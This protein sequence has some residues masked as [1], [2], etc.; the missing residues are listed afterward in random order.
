M[1]VEG[2]AGQLWSLYNGAHADKDKRIADILLDCT[3]RQLLAIRDEFLRIP[4]KGL[5]RQAHAIL[6]TNSNEVKG[7]SVK[8]S[9]GKNEVSEQKRSLAFKARDDFRALK[10]LFLGR[11]SEEMKLIKRLYLELAGADATDVEEG[12]EAHV[13]RVFSSADRDRLSDLL[14]G[15]SAHKEAEI[16]HDMLFPK[17]LYHPI[18]DTLSDPRDSVDRDHTQGIGP[19]LRHFRKRRMWAG[20]ESIYHRVLNCYEVLAERIDAL[21]TERFIATNRALSDIY[22]YE[23]DASMFSSRRIFDPRMTA[24]IIKERIPVAGDFFEMVAPIHLREPRDCLAVQQA[25]R[26]LYGINLEDS[27]RTRLVQ[28]GAPLSE[29]AQTILIE[30]YVN[31]GGR[32]PLSIDILGRYRGVEAEPDVWQWEYKSLPE[33]DEESITLAQIMDQDLEVGEF[34]RP[35]LEFLSGRE[36]SELNRI[37]RAFFELTEPCIALR[38]ALQNCLSEEAFYLTELIFAGV[39]LQATVSAL[40]SDVESCQDLVDLPPSLIKLIREGFERVHFSGLDQYILDIHQGSDQE[41]LLIERLAVVLTPE[42]YKSRGELLTVSRA[43]VDQVDDIRALCRGPL[44]FVMAFE[45][46]FDRLFPRLRVQLKYAAARMA[47]STGVFA[48]IILRLEGVDPDVPT[49]ILEYFDGVDIHLL[50]ET[51]RQY[52]HE[53][54]VI[55]ESYDLLNP[56]AQLKSCIKEMKVDPDLIN[57]T[58]LHLD[59]YS[60]KEVAEEINTIINQQDGVLTGH[61]LGVA[62]L[63]VLAVPTP[64]R[65]NLRI[66]EDI[67]WMDEMAYQVLLAYYRDYGADLVDMCRQRGFDEFQLEE[68][69][70]RLFGMEATSLA[71]ELFALLKS[72]KSGAQNTEA[73][74]R[75]ILSYVESR[76]IRYRARLVRAYNSFWAYHTGFESLLDDVANFIVDLGVRKKLHA[77]LLAVGAEGK[78]RRPGVLIPIQ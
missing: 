26:V 6:N 11:S 51:L 28:I 10:Y 17:G 69:T 60:A 56:D 66:P 31:G 64:Q 19:Y 22:G 25:Y 15:W 3:E 38:T 58:L 5:A 73:A 46:G 47:L 44:P 27:I 78:S 53:Q 29:Q 45:R 49:L 62:V 9:I 33:D 68:L 2:V 23:L 35:V 72:N 20:R 50:L 61:E 32:W 7:S 30:R 54:K 12:L 52:K 14:N 16:I 42:V 55:E 77:L 37:E 76:G 1:D 43:S 24:M 18:D 36:Y 40:H 13:N 75:R 57:E 41:D 59:G 63:A 34:D 48:E 21:S 67:N 70:C 39:D 74:E 65:P 8:K 71:R 4:Y